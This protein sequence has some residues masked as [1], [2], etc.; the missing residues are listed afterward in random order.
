MPI[1]RRPLQEYGGKG[2]GLDPMS[3]TLAILIVLTMLAVLVQ[4]IKK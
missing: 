1:F 3:F 4:Q 2:V